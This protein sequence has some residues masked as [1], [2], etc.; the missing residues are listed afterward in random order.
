MKIRG[1]DPHGSGAYRAPRGRRLHKG[2]DICCEQG[3]SV[4]ALSPG[5]V[6]KVGYPYAQGQPL[7][8]WSDI[9]KAK[10]NAKKTLRYVQVTDSQGVD[11]RY[12]YVKPTVAIGDSISAGDSLGTAQGLEGIYPGITEHYHFEVLVMINGKKV[13]LDPEQ[14]IKAVA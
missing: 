12:F 8:Q 11:V 1:N 14:Y 3:G 10:Y 13:F 7:P 9:K 4:A 6:T 2:I 5:Q